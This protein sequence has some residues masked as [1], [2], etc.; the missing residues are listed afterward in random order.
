[1][2][3]SVLAIA[4]LQRAVITLAPQRLEIEVIF[5]SIDK[6]VAS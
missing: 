1:V 2:S 4:G 3:V 5:Q 6:I